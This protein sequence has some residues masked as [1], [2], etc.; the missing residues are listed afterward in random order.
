M[1]DLNACLDPRHVT[2]IVDNDENK[3][4]VYEKYVHSMMLLE[5]LETLLADK[6]Y[7]FKGGTSLLLLFES[8]ARFSIDIDICMD[9]SEF[10]NK[11]ALEILFRKNIKAPFVDVVRDKNR[12]R[13]GGRDIKA[14][15]YRFFYNPKFRTKENYVLLDASSASCS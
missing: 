1:I 7:I 3:K 13:H 9:E 12:T 14:T 8:A 2:K 10:D 11:D 4:D 6:H 15:H 5:Q